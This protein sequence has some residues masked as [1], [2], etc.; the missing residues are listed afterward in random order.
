MAE[1]LLYQLQAHI[2]I[3]RS[4]LSCP[5]HCSFERLCSLRSLFNERKFFHQ[6]I[7]Q[8]LESIGQMAERLW[9]QLQDDRSLSVH[10]GSKERGFESHFVQHFLLSVIQKAK[11]IAYIF[12]QRR[13]KRNKFEQTSF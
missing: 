8:Y 7:E 5:L 6:F 12:E 3:L 4:S 13:M 11:E 1:Q 10:A 9:R 2:Y